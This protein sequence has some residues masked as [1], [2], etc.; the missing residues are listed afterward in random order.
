MRCDTIYSH[1]AQ[2]YSSRVFNFNGKI[3]NIN[4]WDDKSI[5]DTQEK[6]IGVGLVT[7]S[8]HKPYK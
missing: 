3:Y 4:K 7:L 2:S 5:L 8:A 1:I 6:S